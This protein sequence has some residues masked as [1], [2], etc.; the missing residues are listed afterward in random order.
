MMIRLTKLGE[1]VAK[2]AKGKSNTRSYLLLRKPRMKTYTRLV[3]DRNG[4]V[5]STD[6]VLIDESR[7][8][9]AA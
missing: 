1:A 7:V 3:I 6:K 5:L 4:R 9:R 2:K 8:F